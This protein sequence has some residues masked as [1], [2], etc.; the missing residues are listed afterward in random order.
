MAYR[1][2]HDMWSNCKDEAKWNKEI[3]RLKSEQPEL[4]FIAPMHLKCLLSKET[5]GL[6]YKEV[7]VIDPRVKKG[8]KETIIFAEKKQEE[9]IQEGKPKK[10]EAK[11]ETEQGSLF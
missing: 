7:V 6:N 5:C 9:P 10:K 1:C 3:A 2:I 8:I 4:K 11:K